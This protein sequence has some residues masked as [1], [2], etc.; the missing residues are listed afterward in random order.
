MLN[1][2][3]DVQLVDMSCTFNQKCVEVAER[4]MFRKSMSESKIN[5]SFKKSAVKYSSNVYI[6]RAQRQSVATSEDKVG[7]GWPARIEIH[8]LVSTDTTSSLRLRSRTGLRSGD[9]DKLERRECQ[10]R[11]EEG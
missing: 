11:T 9:A 7:R 4:T 3:L 1:A 6:L 5:S 8:W 10:R 2:L